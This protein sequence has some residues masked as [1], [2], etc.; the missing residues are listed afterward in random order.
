M[1][2]G[3]IDE[4]IERAAARRGGRRAALDELAGQAPPGLLSRIGRILDTP[5]RIARSAVTGKSEA[6]G[7]DVLRKIGLIG[8][9]NPRGLDLGDV[10]GFAAEVALDPL[11]YLGGIGTLTKGGKAATQLSK[12]GRKIKA[13]EFITEGAK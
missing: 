9:R 3:S 10:A 11:T 2:Q 12:V 5:G 6:T 8:R 1:P 7:R 4:I 13:E